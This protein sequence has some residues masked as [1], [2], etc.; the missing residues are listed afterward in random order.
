MNIILF[1]TICFIF[2][3]FYRMMQLLNK[4][5]PSNSRDGYI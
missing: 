2:I 1:Y 3:L 5:V 4:Y